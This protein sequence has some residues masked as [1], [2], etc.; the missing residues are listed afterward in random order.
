MKDTALVVNTVQKNRDLWRMF[1]GQLFKYG[2][3]TEPSSLH[4]FVDPPETEDNS[5]FPQTQGGNKVYV[6]YYD[7]KTKYRTQFVR[8]I[9]GVKEEFCIY[10]SEDYILYDE[11]KWELIEE[12]RDILEKNPRLS[13]IRFNKGGVVDVNFP[14]FQGRDDLFELSNIYPYFYT[15]QVA[16]W[17]TR[18]LE[19]IHVEGPDLHIAGNNM[20]EMFEPA[21]TK[22]CRDLDIQGLFCYHGE[23]KRGKYHYD[24][25]VF[26]HVATALVKGKW[27]ISEYRNELKP[28]FAEYD[29]EEYARGIR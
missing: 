28:L 14:K 20:N 23:P 3:L 8:C 21:A 1:F 13:F 17:R 12:Y 22:T 7:P 15:N 25:T 10:I 5:D 29:I 27:N 9:S 11:P 2:G 6:H 18:D 26:P 16:I 4:I 19:K 24:T